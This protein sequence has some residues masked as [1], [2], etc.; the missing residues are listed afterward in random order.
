MGG[1]QAMPSGSITVR[2]NAALSTGGANLD[3]LST[4]ST[5]ATSALHL[6]GGTTTVGGFLKSSVGA[7]QTSEVDFNGGMLRYGG[8]AANANFLPVLSGLTAKVQAGGARIDDGGQAITIAQS[9][10]HDAALGSAG[11]GGLTKVGTGTVA[12]SGSNTYAGG[13]SIAGGKL[14]LGS[15]AYAPVT[16]G[17]GGA[18]VNAGRLVFDYTGATSPAGTV[19]PLLASAAASNFVTGQIRSGATDATHTL[20]YYDDGVSAL[21]VMFTYYGDLNLDGVVNADDYALLD[22]GFTGHLG[23]WSNGDVNYDGAVDAAD[24]LLV[25]RVV[26]QAQGLSPGFLAQRE[27]QFGPAY[28]QELVTTVPEPASALICL[29]AELVFLGRRRYRR[30]TP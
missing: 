11:D 4:T 29:S 15:A 12:L 21:T 25:D 17:A 16:T 24:Y 28:V 22:R 1:G 20:G 7:G 30:A 9:L 26:G 19:V 5:T 8:S 14:V 2:D 13:T 3:L 18:L 6:D 23:G 27:S 10:V